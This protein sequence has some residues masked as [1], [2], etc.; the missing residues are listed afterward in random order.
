ML[1]FLNA[2][3]Q[4]CCIKGTRVRESGLIVSTN[5]LPGEKILFFRTDC[6]E[7]RESLD[8]VGESLKICDYLVLYIKDGEKR[9]IVCFL[10][11][12]GRNL[13]DAVKQVLSTRE[14]VVALSKEEIER[15]HHPN[16]TWKACICLHGT[17]PR[18][19][20]SSLNEL[21]NF[22]AKPIYISSMA[23]HIINC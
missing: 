12:K 2:R 7:G 14:R 22:L 21:L 4:A 1:S 20:Q 13:D 23:L 11:L 16:I 5:T 8:M 9:E 6:H 18:N 10:E 19:R 15:K 3:L 17:A